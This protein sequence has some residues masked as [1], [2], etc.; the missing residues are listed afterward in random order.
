MCGLVGFL[1]G[2]LPANERAAAV[3]RMALRIAHRG[4]DDSGEYVDERAGYAIGF[5]RL[6]IVDLSPAGHQPM[7]SAT[8]RYVMAFNG[9]VYNFEQIRA[10][11]QSRGL[12]PSWR[13]HSDSEVM[14]A[15]F[16]AWGVEQAVKRFIGMF[17]IALWDRSEQRVHLV[18]DRMGVKPLYFARCGKT[19]LFGSELKAL[20]AHPEFNCEI[21]RDALDAY[22]R[23]AYIPTPLTIYKGVEKIVPG[24]IVSVTAS[25]RV[26]RTTYWSAAAAAEA[27]AANRFRGTEDE[28]AD[29][30]EALLRDAVGL[31]M[32]ADVPLG[33]F[34]SGGIDSSIVTALMQAQAATPVKTFSIG[35]AEEGYD[36]AKHAAAV[37]GHLQT[38]HTEQYVTPAEA[39]AVIPRL[40]EMYDEPFADSSQIPTHLVSA[41]ARRHVTVSLS[42]DGG[43]ELFGGYYRYFMGQR[44]WKY[45]SRVPRPLRSV[46]ANAIRSVNKSTWD[47]WADRAQRLLPKHMEQNR[48]GE[49]LHK[50][51]RILSSRDEDAMYFELVTHWPGIVVGGKEAPLPLTDR[52]RWPKLSDPVER[53]MYFD[54]V[55]YM[56]D[57]ILVKV[58]RASMATSLE[59]R[60]PLLDH[61]L[62]EFAWTLPLSMKVRE[63]Q[64]KWLLRK[65]LY[66]HIPRELVERP[67]M[68]FGIPIG[69]WLRGPMR[70]WAEAL[71][72]ERRI[73]EEGFLDPTLIRRAWTDHLAGR[74][75][76]QHYLWIALMFQAWNEAT[77]ETALESVPLAISR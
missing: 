21:D 64:G 38:Q 37:A 43:D 1:G 59:A 58:D 19:I 40:G 16:E 23:F 36:E 45:I 6:S 54:Q 73:R 39:M 72:D 52:S 3:S 71:L 24:T 22:F 53:M 8:G 11:L 2:R 5:R 76:W 66:R 55:S 18:R 65:V 35:F 31:R 47:R 9:E 30:L 60:E 46:T 67:K 70:E 28:A 74:G 57:D 51:S 48:A 44:A 63:G 41:M 17:A 49:R 12:A 61:R 25:G 77:H 32:I 4:P 7:Q 50:L 34:L 29:Q 26:E 75:E 33:V 10:E 13:G 14:L 68:G 20:R 62:V 56:L 42:G 27:G 69:D 15:A